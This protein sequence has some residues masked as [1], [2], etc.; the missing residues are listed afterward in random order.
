MRI[1]HGAKK[2]RCSREVY[3]IM[4]MKLKNRSVRYGAKVNLCSV[5]EIKGGRSE[6]VNN[7]GEG[8]HCNTYGIFIVYR[9]L[10]SRNFKACCVIY[11]D[12]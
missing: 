6:V 12:N 9:C 7:G 8:Y 10:L 11:V 2:N 3:T 1:K 5:E 4:Q